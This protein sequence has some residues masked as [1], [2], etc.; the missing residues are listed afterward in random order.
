[1]EIKVTSCADFNIP[2][3]AKKI[4][5]CLKLNNIDEWWC[6]DCFASGDESNIDFIRLHAVGDADEMVQYC[7]PACFEENIHATFNIL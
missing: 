5:E 2:P 4:G 6:P 3:N 7:C 1:M